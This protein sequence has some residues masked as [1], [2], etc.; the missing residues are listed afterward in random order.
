M[1]RL[2]QGRLH[3]QRKPVAYAGR[4]DIKS[5]KGGDSVT[6]ERFEA[7]REEFL[8]HEAWNPVWKRGEYSPDE[9]ILQTFRKKAELSGF[10]AEAI[11]AYN[12]LRLVRRIVRAVE[13]GKYAWAWETEDGEGLKQCIADARNYLL[14][15][16]ALLEDKNDNEVGGRG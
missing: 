1:S 16:A 4:R 13:T 12:S 8:T 2:Y 11:L 3:D 15:L 6:P 14:L 9:D 7:L 5:Q 10:P